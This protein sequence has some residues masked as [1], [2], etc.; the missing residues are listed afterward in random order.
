MDE[1]IRKCVDAGVIVAGDLNESIR[2]KNI[3][4]FVNETDIFDVFAETSGLEEDEREATHQHGIKCIDCVLATDGM[5]RNVKGCELVECS[6]IVES[7][8]RGCLTDVDFAQCFQKI[9]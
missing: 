8:H 3:K 7:D 5:L 1:Q 2:S 4:N 6:E 9:S